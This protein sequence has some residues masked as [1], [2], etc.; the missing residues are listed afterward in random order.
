MVKRGDERFK[1]Y[2]L[3]LKKNQ[4]EICLNDIIR[5]FRMFLL[6]DLPGEVQFPF[7]SGVR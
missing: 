5:I 4:K 2:M 3:Y 1:S 6:I 7:T